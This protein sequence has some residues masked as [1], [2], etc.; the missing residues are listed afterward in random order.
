MKHLI[1]I[2]ARGWGREIYTIAQNCIGYNINFDIKGFLDDKSEALNGML[3]YPPILTSP[4][5]YIVEPD[6]VFITA[7]G[8]AHWKKHYTELMLSK[9]AEFINL[10]HKESSIGKNTKIGIGCIMDS[11]VSISCDIEIGNFVT[12][13]GYAIVGH[14]AKIADYAHLGVRTFMGGYSELGKAATLQTGSIVLP[15]IHIGN[16]A[17]VGAGSVAIRKVQNNTT[18][19]GVPAKK[20]QF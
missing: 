3:G 6:D 2:G 7:L 10:I 19:F 8:D 20:V 14:D 1:I 12:F 18:V 17:T 13:Q 15:H 5:T 16:D 4:E 11:N 9:K